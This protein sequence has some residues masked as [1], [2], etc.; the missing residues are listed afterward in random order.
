[1]RFWNLFHFNFMNPTEFEEFLHNFDLQRL[2]FVFSLINP[3]R[4]AIA[5]LQSQYSDIFC[6]NFLACVQNKENMILHY[7]LEWG[8]P[9]IADLFALCIHEYCFDIS[10]NKQNRSEPLVKRLIRITFVTL[11]ISSN[12]ELIWIS[13]PHFL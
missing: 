1:M 6:S 12:H 5:F 3:S 2:H 7:F 11:S 8:L 4:I 13:F 10:W 9:L